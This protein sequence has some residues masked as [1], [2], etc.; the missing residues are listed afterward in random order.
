MNFPSITR[1]ARTVIAL[2]LIV[3]V[4]IGLV[5]LGIFVYQR[6]AV[7][8]QARA[9]IEEEMVLIDLLLRAPLLK[10]EFSTGASILN[11]WALNHKRLVAMRALSPNG[12]VVAEWFKD[13]RGRQTYTMK[14]D[15]VFA[16]ELLL[17]IT[18]TEELG[19]EAAQTLKQAVWM[20]VVSIAM[21]VVLVLAVWT[22]LKRMSLKPL[23]EEVSR[24][25]AAELD[26]QRSRDEL[27]RRVIERTEELAGSRER[28]AWHL[29][30]TPLPYIEWSNGL[31]VV[32]WNLS[33][34][35]IFGYRR[36]EAMNRQA[37]E[38]IV[39][40]ENREA[41]REFL[42]GQ[43]K[44]QRGNHVRVENV[45][46]DGRWLTCEWYN[47]TL[48][49]KDGR[50]IG[51]ASLIEDVTEK[52]KAETSLRE[53]QERFQALFN[54]SADAIFLHDFQA[55][56]LDANQTACDRY[57]YSREELSRRSVTDIDAETNAPLVATRMEQ[58]GRTGSTIFETEHRTKDGRT[59]PVEVNAN[60]M[61]WEDR[62]VI[63]ATCR[64]ISWRKEAERRLQ[65]A[66]ADLERQNEELKKL[67]VMKDGLI[68]DVTHELKTPVAKYAMQLELLKDFLDKRGLA[69][70]SAGILDVMEESLRRQEQVISNILNLAR[71]Q[72]GG[73]PYRRE[74]VALDEL[75]ERVIDDYAPVIEAH[76][77]TVTRSL[78]PV[79]V[80]SDREM[81]WHVFSNIVNNA[82][83]FR[84]ADA[85]P[86]VT[87]SIAL[88]EA[89]VDVR[90]ADN[91]IGMT[92]GERER[93]FEGFYQA[94]AS[95]EGSGVGLTI[96][97]KIVEDLGGAI[98]LESPGKNLGVTVLVSLPR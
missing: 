90:I 64:D 11:Q 26:L 94:S 47:T 40:P 79:T 44:A 30:Q 10:H 36:E 42:L 92:P 29:R 65:R 18:V 74:E 32:D 58:L 13:G 25:Q 23:E 85:R 14:K 56:I 89:H 96:A 70:P 69:A 24:R 12:F 52:L 51:V 22:T 95:F 33:A 93:V 48:R 15:V 5:N 66:M 55:R 39:L 53:S 54:Y 67:D 86:G 3:S 6:R 80:A 61:Q 49:D 20:I 75:L 62:P 35:R 19:L 27:E 72:K 8:E 21:V 31:A 63:L 88:E 76:G 46:K 77:V 37:H 84:R 17:T 68:R 28:L 97:K 50:L 98:R 73:R 7:N 43:T 57:G 34:E 16:G 87:V 91:G 9:G 4:L 1:H 41:F 71:L 38:L 2:A 82:I 59:F 81:L 60:L 45:T 83:K 78:E